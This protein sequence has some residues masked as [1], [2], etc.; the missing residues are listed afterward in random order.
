[1]KIVLSIINLIALVGAIVWCFIVPSLEPVVTSIT[2]LGTLLAQVFMSDELSSK[3]S[4]IQ[5]IKNASHNNIAGR[6][7]LITD[8]RTI[9]TAGDSS[10]LVQGQAITVN[11]FR[12]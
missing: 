6:D 3:L 12:S 10:H 7:Q 11:H 8:N 9:Q 2:L 4:W 5:K 1:M